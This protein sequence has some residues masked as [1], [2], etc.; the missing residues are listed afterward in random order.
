MLGEDWTAILSQVPLHG[1]KR[2]SKRPCNVFISGAP[3]ASLLCLG[4]SPRICRVK[5]VSRI[6]PGVRRTAST[7][8]YCNEQF[9]T[10][11]RILHTPL[12]RILFQSFQRHDLS[13]RGEPARFE[14]DGYPV[15]MHPAAPGKEQHWKGIRPHS[16]QQCGCWQRRRFLCWRRHSVVGVSLVGRGSHVSKVKERCIKSNAQLG[17]HGI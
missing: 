17:T 4:P 3:A 8:F 13:H 7:R 10:A 11:M 1:G 5:L 6:I 15:A 16:Q 9:D 14:V 12:P 2:Y